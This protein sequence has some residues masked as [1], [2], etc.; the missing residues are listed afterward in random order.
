MKH[1]N[2]HPLFG[3]AIYTASTPGFAKVSVAGESFWLRDVRPME[4]DRY[5]AKVDNKL[6]DTKHGLQLDDEVTFTPWQPEVKD[7]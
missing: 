6:F 3:W 1:L 4:S 2:D 7:S 5:S